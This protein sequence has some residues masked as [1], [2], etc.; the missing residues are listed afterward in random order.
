MISLLRAVQ[1]YI[2]IYIYTYMYTHTNS[3]RQR[4]QIPVFICLCTHTHAHTH[5]LTVN[6]CTHTYVS[7]CTCDLPTCI[8]HEEEDTCHMRRRMHVIWGGGYMYMRLTYMHYA[9][10]HPH[11]HINT[12]IYQIIYMLTYKQ[13]LSYKYQYTPNIYWILTNKYSYI[14][15]TKY[16]HI[17]THIYHISAWLW[18]P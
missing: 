16:S 4:F 13:I 11:I 8:M 2:Y 9:C 14:P 17:N 10:I 3:P 12:R 7:T 1:R 5:T 15:Y 6:G 18:S